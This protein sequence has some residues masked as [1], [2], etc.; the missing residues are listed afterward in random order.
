MPKTKEE[1]Y[2]VGGDWK[3]ERKGRILKRTKEKKKEIKRER[4][5]NNDRERER[6]RWTDCCRWVEFRNRE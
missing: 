3:I 6:E 1:E 4:E 5:T 2:D